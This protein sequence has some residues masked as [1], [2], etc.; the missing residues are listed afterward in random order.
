MK[1]IALF[2][3]L[4]LVPLAHAGTPFA[5][6]DLT[7]DAAFLDPQ[8]GS[9]GTRVQ[10]VMPPS[11][12][13]EVFAGRSLTPPAAYIAPSTHSVGVRVAP[14]VQAA[15]QAESAGGRPGWDAGSFGYGDE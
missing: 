10:L 2:G 1:G 12:P 9:V 7:P 14:A 4:I 5:G 11:Q 15:P 8:S 13:A 6:R 3:L